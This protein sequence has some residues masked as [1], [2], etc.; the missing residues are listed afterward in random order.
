[1]DDQ[2]GFSDEVMLMASQMFESASSPMRKAV[3]ASDDQDDFSNE[4]LLQASQEYEKTCNTRFGKAITSKELMTVKESA[5]APRTRNSTNWAVKVWTVWATARRS[6][7]VEEGE[8]EF[9]LSNDI[10][11]MCAKSIAFWL[12]KFVMEARKENGEYYPPNSLYSL[13]CG[14]QRHICNQEST[15]NLFTNDH[16]EHICKVLDSQMKQLNPTGKF[17]KVSTDV[18]TEE[19]ENRLWELGILGD[20]TP[21]ALLNSMFYYIGLY[22]A[23]RGGEEHRRLRHEPAQIKC[24]NLPEKSYI[25]YTE[26]VSK[27]NQGGLLHRN[28]APKSVKHYQNLD[29]PQRCLVRLF[30]LYNERCPK[31]RPAHAFYLKP[32]KSPKGN[33]W[34]QKSPLGHNTLGSMIANMMSS[35]NIKGQFSNH[36][37]RSTATTRLFN[38]RV[39]EQLIMARTGHSSINGV[40][41][42]KRIHEQLIEETSNALNVKRKKTEED[43]GKENEVPSDYSKIASSLGINIA[44]SNVTFNI[45]INKM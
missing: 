8:H 5:I 1:M 36:S 28:R 37:L 2:C 15:I 9:T 27:T 44:S 34:F 24:F 31:D 4:I 16:F 21:Q 13:C 30:N 19:M 33:V 42:Y 18:I 40:R 38:A 22:F 17:T 25:V 6:N 20:Q 32:L 41:T 35:A 23:L 43:G 11:S 45:N 29:C 39:D 26:D 10:V 12:P 14:L 3:D 7:L